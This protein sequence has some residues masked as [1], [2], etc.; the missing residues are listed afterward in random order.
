MNGVFLKRWNCRRHDCTAMR[1][2]STDKIRDSSQAA[3]P[4]PA[5][6]ELTRSFFT[7]GILALQGLQ[8]IVRLEMKTKLVIHPPGP[9]LAGRL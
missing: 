5:F 4:G 1:G 2:I 6:P 8:R 9:Q 3:T 7:A